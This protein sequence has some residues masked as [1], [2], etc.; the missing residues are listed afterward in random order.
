MCVLKVKKVISLVLTFFFAVQLMLVAMPTLEAGAEMLNPSENLSRELKVKGNKIV[1]AEDES[2]EVVLRGVNLES[3]Y[4]HPTMMDVDN[5]FGN[6]KMPGQLDY[7]M[8]TLGGNLI[9]ITVSVPAWLGKWEKNGQTWNDPGGKNYRNKIDQVI[10]EI[11]KAGKYAVLDMHA[12]NR[13]NSP[14]HLE[15][16]DTAAERYKNNPT[17]LFGILNEPTCDWDEW[18]NGDTTPGD[19]NGQKSVG[20]QYMVERIRDLGAKNIII[21]GGPSYSGTLSKIGTNEGYDLIDRGSNNDL[22]KAGN[23]IMYDYH[24]YPLHGSTSTWIKGA[25]AARKKHPILMGEFGWQA[26]LLNHNPK[27]TD[28]TYHTQW[29]PAI[30]DWM[31]DYETYGNYCNWTAFAFHPTS[32]PPMLVKKDNWYLDFELN[33]VFGTYIR[34]ELKR[35]Q[36]ST[37]LTRYKIP[38]ASSTEDTS[39]ARNATDGDDATAWISGSEPGNKTLEIDLGS[40]GTINRWNVRHASLTEKSKI[41]SDFKLQYKVNSDDPWQDADS[42]TGNTYAVTDRFVNVEARYVR[43]LITKPDQSTGN[44]ANIYEFSVMGDAEP[45]VVVPITPPASLS[46]QLLVPTGREF[47]A[48]NE[49]A[50]S[51]NISNFGGVWYRDPNTTQQEIVDVPEGGKAL[52]LKGSTY[53]IGVTGNRT[54]FGDFRN[55]KGFNFRLKSTSNLSIAMKARFGPDGKDDFP[56]YWI[57]A[58]TVNIPSTGGEWKDVWVPFEAFLPDGDSAQEKRARE[59]WQSNDAAS[60]YRTPNAAPWAPDGY[61]EGKAPAGYWPVLMAYM[62]T[63]GGQEVLISNIESFTTATGAVSLENINFT[64][65]GFTSNQGLKGGTTIITTEINNAADKNINGAI[66]AANLYKRGDSKTVASSVKVLNLASKSTS[67]EQQLSLTIPEGEN[68]ADYYIKV[69]LLSNRYFAKPL[70]D[71]LVFDVNGVAGSTAGTY[72]ASELT[73]DDIQPVNRGSAA[74][75]TAKSTKAEPISLIVYKE[76]PHPDL[77]EDLLYID[78]MA[79]NTDG[80]PKA[81]FNFVVRSNTVPMDYKVVAGSAGSEKGVSGSLKVNNEV[82]GDTY[83]IDLSTTGTHVFPSKEQGYDADTIAP[84]TV[85]ATNTG[86]GNAGTLTISK[87]GK[88]PDKF[89]LSKSVLN[90]KDGSPDSF[91]V[92]PAPGIERP[93]SYSATIT[94]SGGEITPKSFDVRFGV[95][96]SYVIYAKNVKGLGN[97]WGSSTKF[98]SNPDGDEDGKNGEYWFKLTGQAASYPQYKVGLPEENYTGLKKVSFWVKADGDMVGTSYSVNLMAGDTELGRIT[99]PKMT[100]DYVYCEF[101]VTDKTGQDFSGLNQLKVGYGSAS[102]SGGFYI[103][104]LKFHL[105]LEGFAMTY[106]LNGKSA[107]YHQFTGAE[108]GYKEQTN[109]TLAVDLTSTG[110]GIPGA[111]D[112]QVKGTNGTPDDAFTPSVSSVSM[113]GKT[114]SFTIKPRTGLGAGE[115]TATVSL[116]CEGEVLAS[117]NVVFNVISFEPKFVQIDN[118][119]SNKIALGGVYSGVGLDDYP[120]AGDGNYITTVAPE[121]NSGINVTGGKIANNTAKF[122]IASPN[123]NAVRLDYKNGSSEVGRAQK[124]LPALDYSALADASGTMYVSFLAKNVGTTAVG[125]NMS[126]VAQGTT[127]KTATVADL[128]AFDIPADDTNW[129]QIT[130]TAKIKDRM[131]TDDIG[132]LNINTRTRSEGSVLISDIILSNCP[133]ANIDLGVVN[134]EKQAPPNINIDGLTDGVLTVPTATVEYTEQPE[135][136]VTLTNSGDGNATGMNVALSTGDAN[137]FTISPTTVSVNGTAASEI[138]VKPQIGLP[139]GI[140][141]TKVI[142]SGGTLPAENSKE[143]AVKFTVEEKAGVNKISLKEVKLNGGASSVSPIKNG[144]L[145]QDSNTVEVLLGNTGEDT[146]AVM[147]VAYYEGNAL[148]DY[149]VTSSTMITGGGSSANQNWLRIENFGVPSGTTKLKAFIWDSAS[150]MIP[151][152]DETVVTAN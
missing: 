17:V 147:I 42:V 127:S 119:A 108:V 80:D 27:P 76:V 52:R 110:A 92:R 111:I 73:L 26:G 106:T 125:V 23:G 30:F 13:F 14:D 3:S 105:E 126:L 10:N 22:S 58:K 25:D 104:Q 49:T 38:S 60:L 1:L 66:L 54:I 20:H 93:D 115:Y 5:V 101:D 57:D 124:K 89:I 69:Y 61:T 86:T 63:S 146:Q 35:I 67:P 71:T 120:G 118:S 97:T 62:G 116:V 88:D 142:I 117:F 74:S 78:Q 83:Q 4:D 9:R 28:A 34:D 102:K 59:F 87:G 143:F 75:I 31:N 123:G 151:L 100:E 129:K 84:L 135:G 6:K 145:K 90:V 103:S 96:G 79:A 41:T 128:G 131:K 24:R 68:P 21:A 8:N 122:D 137:K 91:T 37:S 50:D 133:I 16:W 64:N 113:D 98:S 7:I 130:Y 99:L 70:V 140:Y 132:W 12:Y 139:A 40:V 39:D 149:R 152:L 15:F 56:K 114:G 29:F 11:S 150:S 72:E 2:V 46:N 51:A 81:E 77:S 107:D 94:V 121:A 95:S 112:V 82:V 47:D 44:V 141:R 32:G 65:A 19:V 134:G 36:N 55:V 136:K 144:K 48:N 33:T 109:N 18:L 53:Q 85:T 148:I 43:L 138:V 45:E